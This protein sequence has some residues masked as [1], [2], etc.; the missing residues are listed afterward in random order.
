MQRGH[1]AKLSACADCHHDA[2]SDYV[3]GDF[4]KP[5]IAR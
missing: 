5:P 3:F 4:A 2:P 1:Q